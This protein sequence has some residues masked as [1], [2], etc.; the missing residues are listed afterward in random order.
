MSSATA[1]LPRTT[2][3]ARVVSLIVLVSLIGGAGWLFVAGTQLFVDSWVA[4]IHLSPHNDRVLQLNVQVTR[5]RGEIEHL[6]AE[7]TRL[8]EQ[9]AAIDVAVR[10]FEGIRSNTA[11]LYEWGARTEGESESAA[12]RGLATLN[13]QRRRLERVRRRER[14]LLE[15]A[16]AN[17][18]AGLLTRTDLEEAEQRMDQAELSLAQNERARIELHAEQR[19]HA[20]HADSFRSAL[21]GEPGA[22]SAEVVT[23]REQMIRLEIEAAR[24]RAERRGLVRLRETARRNLAHLGAVVDELRARPVYRAMHEPIDLAFVPYEQLEGVDAGATVVACV[25]G[26]FGCREVGRITEIVPGEVVTQ[27]PW[28]ELARG[29]YAVL[30]LDAPEAVRERILRVRAR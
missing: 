14:A 15:R 22:P 19:A 12:S 10:R 29:R 18:E 20:A 27:D 21:A 11:H 2:G 25:W 26:I 1:G 17:H 6:E 5:Q 4:P 16:R 28:G 24:L 30:E 9:I 7:V 8:D 23:R 3:V 13:R